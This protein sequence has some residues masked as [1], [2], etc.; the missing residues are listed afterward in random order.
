[1]KQITTLTAVAVTT[2]FVL[3]SFTIAPRFIS[4]GSVTK[5]E[6]SK[7]AISFK[8]DPGQS[9]LT[10]LAKKVTGEHAGTIQVR[11]GSLDVDNN[12]LKG[13][14]FEL[15][16]KTITVTDIEDKE[17][18]AK[19]LGHLKSDDFFAVEKFGTAKFVITSA[20]SKG[21]GLYQIKGNLTI[22]GITNEVT[23]PANVT[24]DNNKLVAKAKIKVD[25]TKYDI[26]F[27][28][29]SFFENLGDKTIYDDFDLD[30]QLVANK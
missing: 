17:N 9:K 26:K 8:V 18:N 6:L 12:I 29:K 13:G 2:V 30:I 10:W 4:T 16:T 21:S 5:L 27:R 28:S 23:F 11:S 7:K 24:V 3:S 25:R 20:Q 14:S 19:L 22:K 15:D 1:M